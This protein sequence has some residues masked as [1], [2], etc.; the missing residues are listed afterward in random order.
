MVE[1]K[2]LESYCK[3]YEEV[4]GEIVDT[5]ILKGELERQQKV[6]DTKISK[7]SYDISDEKSSIWFEKTRE[8]CN[9]SIFLKNRLKKNILSDLLGGTLLISVGYFAIELP[10]ILVLGISSV[11]TISQIISNIVSY[12]KNLN[13]CSVVN[14][15]DSDL[16]S[17]DISRLVNEKSKELSKNKEIKDSLDI[18]NRRLN[19]LGEIKLDI[20]N[21]IICLFSN[22]DNI[23]KNQSNQKEPFKTWLNISYE[24][25]EPKLEISSTMKRVRNKK[26]D[27]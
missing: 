2:K 7:L 12:K 10:L 22:L 16:I 20:E 1:E 11:I 21:L 13:K 27:K 26:E 23:I 24:E 9:K 18:V 3:K 19:S 25:D 6:S 15:K 4:K 17:E 8:L 5:S 14:I